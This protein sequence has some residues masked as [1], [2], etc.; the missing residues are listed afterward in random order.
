[1]T[2]PVVALEHLTISVADLDTEIDN[3]AVLLDLKPSWRGAQDG[4]DIAIFNT[5]NVAVRLVASEQP[6]GLE[7][8]CFAVDSLQRMVRRLQRVGIAS[9]EATTENPIT[10]SDSPKVMQIASS[11][12]TR[13]IQMSFVE[14]D[15]KATA[16]QATA[17]NGLDHIV[18]ASQ[19]AE[20]TA[21]LLGSQLG[22]DMRM[23]MS[24]PEWKA[25]LMF[26]R[27][28]DL[29]VEV[30]EHLDENAPNTEDRTSPK[31]DNFYGLTWRVKDADASHA[32]LSQA[33]FDTSEV[34]RGRKRGSKVLTVRDKTAEVATLL[35]ELP[36]A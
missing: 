12:D 15:S 31:E 30:F 35:I 3:Y 36:V 17:S 4:H 2:S 19:S 13:G 18:I 25:R 23:D 32:R 28:G 26:F 7:A 27:C 1:M 29:I 11:P 24:R 5:D 33:G 6:R 21:F 14:G 34:R 20:S 16:K 22:L 8:V 10:P 9:S